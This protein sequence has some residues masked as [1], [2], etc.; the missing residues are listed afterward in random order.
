MT[1]PILAQSAGVLVLASAIACVGSPPA[2]ERYRL[3]PSPT[4]GAAPRPASE[5]T[6]P[7]TLMVEPYATTGIYADPQI[8]YRLGETTYGAY[9]NKEWALPLGAMLADATVQ[10][11]RAT[12]GLNAQVSDDRV[13]RSA[14]LV[15]RGVVQ[16]FEEVDRGKDVSAAVRLDAALVRLPGDSVL[17]QGTVAL[18]GPVQTP[19][20]TAIVDTLSQLT[21][22]AIRQLVDRAQPAAQDG[23]VRLSRN[24]AAD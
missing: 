16:Q 7:P 4:T 3:V 21:S 5:E 1:S 23:G 13:S 19:S 6:D 18:E 11:L 15:W 24:R 2:L 12:P 17:W 22:R 9:P 14:E 20:M 10:A 8:V